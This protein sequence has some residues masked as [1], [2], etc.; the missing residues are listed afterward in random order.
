[1]A[2]FKTLICIVALVWQ[3][4]AMAKWQ[5]DNTSSNL[6]FISTKKH[7]VMEVH[8]FNRLSG[9]ISEQGKARLEIDLASVNTAIPIRDERMKQWLFE[10]Q[11]YPKA[12][13]ELSI[14]K[15]LINSLEVGQS[16]QI[17]VK[18]ELSL[19]GEKQAVVASILVTKTA[20]NSVSVS[21]WQP[22]LIQAGDFNLLAGLIKLQEIAQLTSISPVVPVSF[23]LN[24]KAQD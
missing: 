17:S 4:P 13:V 16:S 2:K 11:Q 5:L 14:D 20:E 10:T 18:A 15:A 3:L 24:F 8:Q 7:T 19:H 9:Y 23:V 21:S 1:M 6:S 22:V 12:D